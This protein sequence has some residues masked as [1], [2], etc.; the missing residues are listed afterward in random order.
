MNLLDW[1]IIAVYIAGL[2]VFSI[3]L[4]R[5]Q[6]STEDYFLGS[7]N[8]PWWAIAISTMATQLSAISFISA[9]AFVAGR[10]GGGLI[11]LGYEF[12]VPLAMIFVMIVILPFLHRNHIVS[13]YEYLEH[14][15]DLGTRTLIS[16]IFQISRALAT[17]VGVYAI[18]IVFSV[19]V[20]MNIWLTILIIG[21]V[22]MVYDTLGGIKAVV[23]TDVVQ[24]GILLIGILVC[25]G[26]ALY[27]VGGWG[28]ALGAVPAQRWQSIDLPPRTSPPSM[29]DPGPF[30]VHSKG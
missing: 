10:P 8:L 4:S 20:G 16:L 18:A 17:G 28:E 12:A 22:A 26:Y 29:L 24:M 19:T 6:K 21:V 7:R 25:S 5:G 11:W 3:F 14:R 2:I 13:I 1:S 30:E 23:Y 27:Y 15:F 9:P